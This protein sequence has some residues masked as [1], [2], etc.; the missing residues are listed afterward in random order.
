MRDRSDAAHRQEHS[1]AA[2]H[3]SP[4]AH[5]HPRD[6]LA[7]PRTGQASGGR[8]VARQEHPRVPEG[9]HG[10]PGSVKVDVDTSPLPATPAA[11]A[12]PAAPAPRS[13][14]PSPRRLPIRR[15]LLL[16]LRR[17][18]TRRPSRASRSRSNRPWQTPTPCSSRVSP[19][20]QHPR[21]GAGPPP[22]LTP[23]DETVMSLVDHLDEL[24]TRLFKSILAVAVASAVGFYFATGIR[25]FLIAP[26]G[27]DGPGPGDRRRVRHPDEDLD[28]RRD[29]PRHADP[30]LPAL[31]V[32]RPGADAE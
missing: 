4:R 16:R 24:R 6:R 31:G 17:R 27:R 1:D 30:A 18:P 15:R 5:H 9:V 21:S 8:F 20:V 14:P 29:H 12:A 19:V 25:G 26:L 2:E 13:P 23:G 3:R 7:D 32:H 28:R 22:A 11:P 10:H